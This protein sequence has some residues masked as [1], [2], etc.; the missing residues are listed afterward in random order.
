M[1][2]T[3]TRLLLVL[4]ATLGACDGKVMYA[5]ADESSIVFTQ[6][7]GT[8]VPGDPTQ[9][10]VSVPTGLVNFT[11]DIPDIPLTGGSPTSNQAGFTI[12]TMMRLNELVLTIPSSTANADFNGIDSVTLTAQSGSQT[13][14]IAT[15]TKDPARLP[16]KVL[17][18]QGDPNVELLDYLVPGASGGKTISL[19]VSFT[20]T[21]PANNW[22]ADVDMDLHVQAKA[23]WP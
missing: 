14:T 7:L 8:I 13:A 9:T 6:P 5:R 16:G 4:G 23:S 10:P 15:Y 3:V 20:G 18:L 12:T 22:T 21:R 1:K 11:Y 19:S 17:A 2:N